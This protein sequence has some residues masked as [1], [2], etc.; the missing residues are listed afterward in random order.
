MD[1]QD[2][3]I[4]NQ[5]ISYIGAADEKIADYFNWKQRTNGDWDEI[6]VSGDHT[7]IFD[8]PNVI[9]VAEHINSRN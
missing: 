8:L 2:S 9:K 3:E 6:H 7:T 5:N 4:I 1:Y